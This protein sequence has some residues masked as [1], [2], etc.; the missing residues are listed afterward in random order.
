MPIHGK[1]LSSVESHNNG[2]PL[3]LFRPEA[4]A[5][6]QQ[7]FY[8]EIILVRPFPLMLLC[9][10]AL[11]ITAAVLG[12][13]FLGQ[14]TERTRVPGLMTIT[15]PAIPNG[16]AAKLEAAVYVPVRLLGRLHHGTQLSL[17]CDS[18]AAQFGQPVGTVMEVPQTPVEP[19]ELSQNNLSFAGPVYKIAVSLPPQA[20]QTMQLNPTPQT[21][22]RVEAEIPL[23]HKP[24]IKWFFERSGS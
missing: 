13:L 18:C 1:T 24:L 8:G 11:G 15:S 7:K 17:R 14:Y 5:A 6:L 12:F 3:P 10:F 21:G 19:A 23:G 4:V 9:W 16:A 22:V 20:A 2:N